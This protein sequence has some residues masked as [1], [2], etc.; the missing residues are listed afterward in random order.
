MAVSACCSS[1]NY[2]CQGKTCIEN[3]T[4]KLTDLPNIGTELAKKLELVGID[5]PGQLKSIG[6]KDAFIRLKT[7]DSSACINMLYALE[8]AVREIRW[9]GL[10][11]EVKQELLEFYRMVSRDV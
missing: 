8:G 4:K 3:M 10:S 5:N 6:S 7:I 11:K 2:F 9:H 1:F